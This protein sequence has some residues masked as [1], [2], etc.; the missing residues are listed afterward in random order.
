[1]AKA[2]EIFDKAFQPGRPPRSA[3]YRAGVLSLLKLKLDKAPLGCPHA[4][5]SAEFD[6]FYAG[7]S[8]GHDLLRKQASEVQA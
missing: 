5:G 3:A 4:P 2:Q 1:M 7:V 6:A 8:E